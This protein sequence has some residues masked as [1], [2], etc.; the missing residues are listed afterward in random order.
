MSIGQSAQIPVRRMETQKNEYIHM[1]STIDIKDGPWTKP[2][3]GT[4]VIVGTEAALE[5][6][7]QACTHL[8]HAWMLPS[9]ELPAIDST[10]P[11][12]VRGSA[13][14]IAADKKA[15]LCFGTSKGKVYTANI[16]DGGRLEEPFASFSNHS[17]PITAIG[18]AFNTGRGSWNAEM[19]TRVVTGD[20]EGVVCVW[21]AQSASKLH[22]VTTIA[23]SNVPV[24]SIGVK[25]GLIIV[26]RVDGN[27]QMYDLSTGSL[28][29]ELGA[30]S[31]GLVCMVSQALDSLSSPPL[32]ISSIP[33]YYDDDSLRMCTRPWIFLP[34]EQRMQLL[35]SGLFL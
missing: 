3:N 27:V 21:D 14:V 23:T 30:H 28:T 2:G 16:L 5:V 12:L 31:R 24:S 4:Y 1:V 6:W 26:A 34:L 8:M 7:D 10:I 13:A 20:Q 22:H 15:L 9:D 25:S 33:P 18:S 35:Q 19:G 17:A 11:A 32:L 29:C